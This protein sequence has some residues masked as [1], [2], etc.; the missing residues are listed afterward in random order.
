MSS[1]LI[2]NAAPGA[3]DVDGGAFGQFDQV[4][5]A[6]SARSVPRVDCHPK[7]KAGV[8]AEQAHETPVPDR[9]LQDRGRLGFIPRAADNPG[10]GQAQAK[11]RRDDEGVGLS[12]VERKLKCLFLAYPVDTHTH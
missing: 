7:V 8:H 4:V 1:D 5:R 2:G 9:H 6:E 12:L 11:I 10:S 3:L